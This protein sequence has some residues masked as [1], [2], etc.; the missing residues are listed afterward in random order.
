LVLGSQPYRRLS[1]DCMRVLTGVRP[2]KPGP[3]QAA[4]WP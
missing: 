1:G 3:G 2:V 4:I